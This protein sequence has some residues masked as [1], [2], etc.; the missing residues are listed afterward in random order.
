MKRS[1]DKDSQSPKIHEPD[2]KRYK[3]TPKRIEY[4]TPLEQKIYDELYSLTQM[5]QSDSTKSQEF[6]LKK[7]K[8]RE[9]NEKLLGNRRSTDQCKSTDFLEFLIDFETG[10]LNQK[11]RQLYKSNVI[12]IWNQYMKKNFLPYLNGP[13]SILK[14]KQIKN[15]DQELSAIMTFVKYQW[16]VLYGGC[17][18]PKDPLSGEHYNVITFL[19]G[20]N[21]CH[22]T[23]ITALLLVSAD[24][25]GLFPDFILGQISHGHIYVVTHR[26]LAIEGSGRQASQIMMG[27]KARV[28]TSSAIRTPQRFV[29][30][31]NWYL[32]RRPFEIRKKGTIDKIQETWGKSI[33]TFQESMQNHFMQPNQSDRDFVLQWFDNFADLK[34]FVKFHNN[35]NFLR[36]YDEYLVLSQ[37]FRDSHLFT[38]S[39]IIMPSFNLPEFKI[40]QLFIQNMMRNPENHR[41]KYRMLFFWT[42]LY[43][44]ID[45]NHY[46]RNIFK[47]GKDVNDTVIIKF[48]HVLHKQAALFI[49][50]TREICETYS[51]EY[52]AQEEVFKKLAYE[53][54][55]FIANVWN[56]V[57]NRAPS[58]DV[59]IDHHNV[60]IL[61]RL[62]K[63]CF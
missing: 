4:Y 19:L 57:N 22:C 63:T 3:M 13:I 58:S 36:L 47:E 48:L 6:E 46:M 18:Y 40:R 14:S 41:K 16:D 28:P 44:N 10:K 17:P 38:S 35:A 27:Y 56:Y 42:V 23:C 29:E 59:T 60:H 45:E 20:Q 8:L 50:V 5:I 54:L 33:P 62:I 25:L 12:D 49:D 9:L 34:T 52:D 26:G 53:N 21:D 15:D 37:E 61:E 24:C 51:D 2:E 7:Q 43:L 30:S 55:E 1:R 32:R 39:R 31:V 11:E